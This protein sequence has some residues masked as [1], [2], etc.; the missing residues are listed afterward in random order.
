MRSVRV[1][2]V[3]AVVECEA[4]RETENPLGFEGG[5]GRAWY[6]KV[7]PSCGSYDHT[8]KCDEE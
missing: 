8:K 7:S 3:L 4:E 5:P 2:K 6:S 1:M